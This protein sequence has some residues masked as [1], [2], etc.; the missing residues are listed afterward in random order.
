MKIGILGTGFGA[1]HASIYKK[2][3]FIDSIIIFGRNEEKLDKIKADMEVR[4]TNNIN[5]I[6]CDPDIDL[7]DICLPNNL[8]CE[9]IIKALE[10]GKNVFCET[11]I[12]ENITEAE[13]IKKAEIKYGKK[14]FINL[15]IKFYPEYRFIYEAINNNTYGKLKAIHVKRKTA[16][17][18]GELGFDTIVTNLML[19]DIDF[20]TWILGVPGNISS[21]GSSNNNSESCVNALLSY[22]DAVAELTGSSM[23]PKTYPFTVGYDAIFENGTIE[24][25]EQFSDAGNQKQLIEYTYS[26]KRNIELDP[27]NPY[28]EAI[29]HVIDC[30]RNNS[31]TVLGVEDAAASLKLALEIKKLIT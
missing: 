31:K 19:H 16:P 30:C 6:L 5:V 17:I 25:Q 15:F 10:N 20:I 28:E 12:S 26:G 23:M 27:K 3:P 21:S 9:Y 1:Y 14:V 7:I 4:T 24:F 18:W 8:H 29:K 2:Q 22:K 13:A 11:K